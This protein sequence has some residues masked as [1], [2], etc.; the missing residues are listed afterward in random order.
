MGTFLRRYRVLLTSG[1]LLVCSL[2][3]ASLSTRSPH[4]RDP[5]AT[6]L[7]D[8]LAP[9][10]AG[11]NWIR[12]GTRNIWNGYVALVGLS[13]EH[14]HLREQVAR[15]GRQTVRLTEV[16]QEN[17]R[18]LALLGL[19]TRLHGLLYAARVIA[20][21][22]LPGSQG[23]TIDLGRRD[24][25]PP[26]MAVLSARGVAGRVVHVGWMA[27]RIL[28]LTDRNSGIDALVQR[29]RARGVLQGG[30]QGQ[31]SLNY[32]P[33]TADVRVGDRVVTSGRSGTFPLGILIG[34]VT[35][36]GRREHGLLQAATVRPHA[37]LDRLE[38]VVVLGNAGPPIPDP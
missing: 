37:Q 7:L 14:Q 21:D 34:T 13:T 33:S 20:R 11:A 6:L 30:R 4:H 8:G 9:L 15:L 26:G 22:P 35:G 25:I 12:A 10:Q 28:L 27:A 32:L 17:E 38:E 16:T 24:G 18:L 23:I 29:T 36:V 19:R 31:C 1:S 3:L 5:L 2:F